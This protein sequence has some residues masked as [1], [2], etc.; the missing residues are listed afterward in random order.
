VPAQIGVLAEL[1]DDPQGGRGVGGLAG[2]IGGRAEVG[3]L[4][5]KA[6]EC[7]LEVDGRRA[8]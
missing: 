2:V 5:V 7:G 1:A 4:G 6:V 3:A 8:L